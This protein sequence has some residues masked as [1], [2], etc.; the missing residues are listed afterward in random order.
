LREALTAT[1]RA[2]VIATILA[3]HVAMGAIALRRSLVPASRSWYILG[4][5]TYPLYLLHSRIGATVSASV[6]ESVGVN[7]WVV[8]AIALAVAY[9]LAAALA[10][11]IE[12]RACGAFHRQLSPRRPVS[13]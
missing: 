12:R 5:L 8:L 10:A 4:G 7:E 3:F 13:A 1:D 6:R 9:G 2:V 11:I